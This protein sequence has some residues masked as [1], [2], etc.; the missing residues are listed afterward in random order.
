MVGET[1]LLRLAGAA[2]AIVARQPFKVP[3][4]LRYFVAITTSQV[5]K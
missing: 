1:R 4:G 5:A 3:N 2:I